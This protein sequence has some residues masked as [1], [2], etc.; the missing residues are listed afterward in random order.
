MP[1]P[2]CAGVRRG[3]RGDGG[4]HPAPPAALVGEPLA[5]AFGVAALADADYAQRT[6]EYVR[7][8][9]ESLTEALQEMPGLYVY[10]AR[11][12][13]CW[14]A[15][16]APDVDAPALARRLLERAS[17]SA[18]SA[19]EQHLDGRFFRVAVRTEEENARLCAQAPAN[20][21]GRSRKL[22]G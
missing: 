10:P 13:S 12:T 17:P 22:A 21:P 20:A 8:Q 14:C 7:A 16:T 3:A 18:R 4:S 1:F 6:R 11:R 5:Q 15:S 9:R 19:A 2:G